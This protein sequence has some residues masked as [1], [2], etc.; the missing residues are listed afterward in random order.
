MWNSTW[1]RVLAASDALRTRRRRG[2]RSI[3]VERL[4]VRILPAVTAVVSKS[5][6]RLTG[7]S[8]PN[9]I[10]ILK[11]GSSV[12]VVGRNGTTIKV[13]GSESSSATFAGVTSLRTS[14]MG[15]NDVVEL[16]DDL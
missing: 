13:G 9:D 6:L 11:N 7:D 14:L 15:S 3:Q 2:A 10:L 4:E 5:E 8:R 16:G 12:Q 1:R